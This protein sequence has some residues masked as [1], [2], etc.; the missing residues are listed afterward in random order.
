MRKILPIVLLACVV[1][2]C[3]VAVSV[4]AAG[5]VQ[6]KLV[7]PFRGRYLAITTRGGA[8]TGATLEKVELRRVGDRL[9]LVGKGI[10]DGDPNNWYKGTTSWVA[11]DDVSQVTEL[12]SLSRLRNAMPKGSP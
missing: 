3:V 9:F 6:S 11:L 1:V 2:G 5:P 4:R 8:N 7:S 12:N 10:D